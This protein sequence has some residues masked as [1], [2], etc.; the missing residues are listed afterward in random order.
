VPLNHLQQPHPEFQKAIFARLIQLRVSDI[1]RVCR[2]P[3][4]P[5]DMR[6]RFVEEK[7]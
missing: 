5:I 1:R 4:I 6:S 7:R 3:R 2:I